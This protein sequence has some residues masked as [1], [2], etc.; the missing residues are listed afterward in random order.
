MP[1]KRSLVMPP[2]KVLVVVTRMLPMSSG[3]VLIALPPMNTV[4]LRMFVV[5]VFGFASKGGS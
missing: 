1:S 3:T 4:E 5:A 2:M